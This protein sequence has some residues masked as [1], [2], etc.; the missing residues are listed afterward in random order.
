MLLFLAP[1]LWKRFYRLS[2]NIPKNFGIPKP[3]FFPPSTSIMYEDAM[4]VLWRWSIIVLKS[5]G[6]IWMKRRKSAPSSPLHRMIIHAPPVYLIPHNDEILV[7]A[8]LY[9]SLSLSILVGLSFSPP[10]PFCYHCMLPFSLPLAFLSLSHQPLLFWRQKTESTMPM[11][12]TT[13]PRIHHHSISCWSCRPS[14]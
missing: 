6:H 2:P 8:S 10:T 4:K 1:L 7:W 14:F 12:P 3:T 9:P 11:A 13:M 5:R